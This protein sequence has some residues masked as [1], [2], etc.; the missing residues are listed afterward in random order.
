[1]GE[2]RV[3]TIEDILDDLTGFWRSAILAASLELHLS[4][5]ILAGRDTAKA[6]AEAE[7]ADP[8]LLRRLLDALCGLGYLNRDDGRYEVA[9]VVE[10]VLGAG[11]TET[12]THWVNEIEWTHSRRLADVVRA[13]KPAEEVLYDHE[14]WERFARATFRTALLQGMLVAEELEIQPG[15]GTRVLDV[16]CGSGGVG[17]G[18]ATSEPSA[19]VT[20]LD[21]AAV[22]RI[23]AEQ[24]EQLGLHDRVTWRPTD[25][26]LAESFGDEEFDVAI[27]SN[28][29]HHCAP[30]SA[31]ELL[32]K[33]ARALVPGG[34]VLIL[35][36]V[37]DDER[38]TTAHQLMF[39]VIQMLTTPGNAYTF[40]EIS[41][42]LAGA[43]LGEAEHYRMDG[44]TSAIVGVKPRTPAVAAARASAAGEAG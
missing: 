39:G 35:D 2:H 25:V 10:A 21:G 15:G 34:R 30:D 17:C 27:V 14:F 28:V 36:V 22:L 42:W 41:A 16:G 5:H 33:V 43:G 7:S 26:L 24:A 13:G 11:F 20:G 38:R 32:T 31:E 23:A 12:A 4:E 44:Y 3:E 9:P 19:T 8:R 18:F 40:A 1:M 6:M 37:P 29:L